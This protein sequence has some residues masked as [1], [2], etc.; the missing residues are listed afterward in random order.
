MREEKNLV[1]SR[2]SDTSKTRA[3]RHIYLVRH[4]QYQTRTKI[5]DDKQLTELGRSIDRQSRIEW[6]S[7]HLG[8]EQADWAGKALAKSK[9]PFSR[10]VQSGL[11]R[12]IQTATIVNKYLSFNNIEQD[13]DLNEG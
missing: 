13:S 1:S 5:E 3:V 4:G 8:N 2:H 9:I 6:I 12:A 10:L 7:V 11:I